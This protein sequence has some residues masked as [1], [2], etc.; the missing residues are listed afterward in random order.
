[1]S[2]IFS[3][4]LIYLK[5]VR[6]CMPWVCAWAWHVPREQKRALESEEVVS[7]YVGAGNWVWIQYRSGEWPSLGSLTCYVY[8]QSV[9]SSCVKRP[10]FSLAD[11]V[12]TGALLRLQTGHLAICFVSPLCSLLCPSFHAIMKTLGLYLGMDLDHWSLRD[13]E[14]LLQ[15]HSA[16]PTLALTKNGLRLS[17]VMWGLTTLSSWDTEE[18][19]QARR[20]PTTPVLLCCYNFHL[21]LSH[22]FFQLCI[23]PFYIWTTP[24]YTDI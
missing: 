4:R 15:L 6:V 12:D 13:V 10:S 19:T 16:L 1:M 7:C 14:T 20:A 24:T 21:T 9:D 3:E 22:H 11:H 18:Q 23:F 17:L 5:C 2:F 8:H